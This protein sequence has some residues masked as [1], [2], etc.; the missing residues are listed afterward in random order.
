MTVL[1]MTTATTASSGT[2][3]G[4]GSSPFQPHWDLFPDFYVAQRAPVSFF[5]QIDGDLTKSAWT[6]V[7]WSAAFGDI[8][9]DDADADA[10][11]SS[12]ISPALTRF[13]ALWDDD[14]LYIGALLHA[15]DDLNTQAH[16]TER[17]SPIFQLDSDFEV[18][19][20][21]TGTN[22][23]YRELEVNALNTVWNLMLDKPYLNDGVEHSGRVTTDPNDA[24]YYEV[25]G[26][27]TAVRVLEGTL[28]DNVTGKGALW[29]VE[30]ALAFSDLNVTASSSSSSS[31]NAKDDN[32][33]TDNSS[34][35]TTNRKHNLNLN[36]RPQPG[37]TA[38]SSSTSTQSQSH[39]HVRIN[40]SRVERQGD[41]N[42][43]W[44][45]QR[46]YSATQ[47]KYQGRVNM[48]LPESWG[49]LVFDDSD[50]SDMDVE[51]QFQAESPKSESA[52]LQPQDIDPTWP[53]QVAA[54]HVYYAQDAYRETT[55]HY[56]F[57]L[58]DLVQYMETKYI[59]PFTVGISH[60]WVT[61]GYRVV[62]ADQNA[63]ILVTVEQDRKLC[64]TVA[65]D[66]DDDDDD[67]DANGTNAKTIAVDK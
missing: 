16:F 1:S 65:S 63:G 24:L 17:N 15:S 34:R 35:P 49:Y 28:N 39:S 20:D 60:T 53:A 26:Q 64:V 13:K 18:F 3:L 11:S 42:W 57:D 45:P 51:E 54:M 21:W 43:T 36:S 2:T 7:P 58:N 40:F 52:I 48:H 59:N 31:N 29:S 4:G 6:N 41:I 62:V 61:E 23:N 25:Y 38:P 19:I 30:I 56:T 14:H 27:Q 9:G 55:G 5:Q 22:H 67:D 32:D 12:N 44:Q 66:S 46:V 10:D 50:N 8:Q 47:H 37:S 33:S